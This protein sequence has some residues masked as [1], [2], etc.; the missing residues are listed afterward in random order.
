[1]PAES[2]CVGQQ[3]IEA[4]H[5]AEYGDVV[6]LYTSLDEEFFDVAVEQVV[7]QVQVDRNRNRPGQPNPA[8]WVPGMLSARYAALARD[9]HPPNSRR[10]QNRQDRIYASSTLPHLLAVN[11]F[12]VA[13]LAHARQHPGSRLRRW[14]SERSTAAAYG[15]RIHPDGHDV[16]ADGD[17]ETGFFLELDRGTE[18]VG[19]LV[20][21]LAPQARLQAAGGPNYPV[22][23]VLPTPAREQHLHRRLADQPEP[24]LM[25]ATTS[26]EAA[27]DPGRLRRLHGPAGPVWRVA[28]NGRH[29]MRLTDL[30]GGHCEPGP[31][32]PAAPQPHD[33]PLRLLDTA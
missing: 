33:D 6:D 16:W 31:L 10:L 2:G 8:C 24:T 18:P 26:P 22:L 25:V 4:L 15:Q 7:P 27:R 14:W 23:F 28:G 5:P 11:D 29:R 30:P 20:D 1:V 32:N 3:W 21:K 17:T 19:R 12:F 9:E 13:L